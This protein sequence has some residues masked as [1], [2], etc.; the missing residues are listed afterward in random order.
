MDCICCGA[1]NE[2]NNIC[3]HH[4]QTSALLSFW[5]KEGHRWR[6]WLSGGHCPEERLSNAAGT[7]PIYLQLLTPTTR[8]P[9]CQTN[10]E[11]ALIPKVVT[12]AY[13]WNQCRASVSRFL[14]DTWQYCCWQ[15]PSLGPNV[16]LLCCIQCSQ[17]FLDVTWMLH[18]A[19][20]IN[21]RLAFVIARISGGRRDESSTWLLWLNMFV[22]VTALPVTHTCWDT[23]SLRVVLFLESPPPVNC[24][25]VHHD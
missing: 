11:A 13:Q 18:G 19:I 21:W 20:R 7:G 15:F 1:A 12:L 24:S 2:L 17:L 10:P 4:K 6:S 22:N 5:W 14:A 8:A 9:S 25:F 3:K 23:L 16:P